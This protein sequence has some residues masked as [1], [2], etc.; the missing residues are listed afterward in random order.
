MVVA[1]QDITFVCFQTGGLYMS[2]KAGVPHVTID[3]SLKHERDST[4]LHEAGTGMLKR[5]RMTE[6]ESHGGHHIPP[7][8]NLSPWSQSVPHP[9]HS[10]SPTVAS[11]S[12]ILGSFSSSQSP[13]SHE[14]QQLPP[15]DH[16]QQPP[17]LNPQQHQYQHGQP[18]SPYGGGGGPSPTYPPPPP[19]NSSWN[20][21]DPN[22]QQQQAPMHSPYGYSNA[23]YPSVYSNMFAPTSGTA[24]EHSPN[25]NNFMRGSTSIPPMPSPTMPQHGSTPTS[26]TPANGLQ[27]L[28]LA[29]SSSYYSDYNP[30]T[31]H[32]APVV[33][34]GGAGGG[35]QSGDLHFIPRA[36]GEPDGQEGKE[37]DSDD[38]PKVIY[39][40]RRG[41]WY[42][43][44]TSCGTHNSPGEIILQMELPTW[45]LSVTS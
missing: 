29:S 45:R 32:S 2:G 11:A 36:R 10:V 17:Q 14:Q 18:H 22:Q 41:D 13:Q 37:P 7:S 42:R 21:S 28:A 33:P 3:S 25:Q 5:P 8:M 26:G 1:Y 6:Q 19:L 23:T 31:P 12:A 38:K 20:N 34:G 15:H 16:H 9:P 39:K 24:S 30:P 27:N 44:C 35:D 4:T 40:G 43:I